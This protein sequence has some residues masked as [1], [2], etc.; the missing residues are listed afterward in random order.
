MKRLVLL[1]DEE[2]RICSY[3][4]RDYPE[5]GIMSLEKDGKTHLLMIN[6]YSIFGE[7]YNLETEKGM[8]ILKYLE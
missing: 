2:N 4:T 8:F 3:S 7:I 6:N 1:V 5:H